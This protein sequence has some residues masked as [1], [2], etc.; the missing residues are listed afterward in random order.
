MSFECIKVE[1]SGGIAT[2]AINRPDKLNAL[3]INTIRELIEAF[4]SIRDDDEV[5][6]SILTGEGKK[7]LQNFLEL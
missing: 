4:T 7:L 5:K 6:V 1:K 3:N 2:V